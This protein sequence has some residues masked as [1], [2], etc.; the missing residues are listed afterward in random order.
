MGISIPQDS[1][2]L[3]GIYPEDVSSYHK[4]TCSVSTAALFIISRN[5]RN[6]KHPRCLSTEERIKKMW[7]IYTMEYLLSS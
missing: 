4:D 7:Y 5:T 3:L 1:A 6:W 2:M